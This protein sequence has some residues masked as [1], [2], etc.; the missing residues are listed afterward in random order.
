MA[1]LERLRLNVQLCPLTHLE[2]ETILK[3]KFVSQPQVFEGSRRNLAVGLE[4]TLEELLQ[5]AKH[6][7]YNQDQ[8]ENKEQ[9]R[10][11]KKKNL[12]P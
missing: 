1:F 5:A 4:R 9:E 6:V 7:Y 10:R 2:A 8:E 11:L 12:R 3:D